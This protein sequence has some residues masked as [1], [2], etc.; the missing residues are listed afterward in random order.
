MILFASLINFVLETSA[1]F[2]IPYEIATNYSM[3]RS[4]REE[5]TQPHDILKNAE[6][7]CNTFFAFEM[8]LRFLSSP[9][10][11]KFL[12]S[13]YNLI[14]LLSILPFF[15]PIQSRDGPKTWAVRMHNYLEVL[16]ILR[17]LRIFVLVPKYSGLRVLILTM[18]SSVGELF[19]Y[20]LLLLMTI[21]I[22]AS[23]AFYAEQIYESD[24][25]Q[26]ESILIGLW[27]AIVTMT[28]L[29]YGDIVPVTPLG[30]VVGAC[31]ALCGL[32]FLALPIPV[33]VNNFTTFYAQA[34]AHK[35]LE[36][37]IPLKKK[38]INRAIFQQFQN[39]QVHK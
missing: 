7:F 1:Y 16:Y 30:R 4:D 19:L 35:K 15:F 38:A 36:S 22:F 3:S 18:K 13:P 31:C 11:I 33:I 29:G 27:W 23:F 14:E 6:R 17:I 21:M 37:F 20:S 5:Y 2:R 9:N 34:K 12:R 32:V 39:I 28:T 24:K 10:K 26:F 8:I 25:N